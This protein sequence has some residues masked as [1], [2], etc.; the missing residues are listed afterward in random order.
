MANDQF[1]KLLRFARRTGDRLIITDEHGGEPLVILP[2]E[3]YESLVDGFLGPDD[4]EIAE[5]E[6]EHNHTGHDHQQA[7]QPFEPEFE[8]EEEEIGEI[9]IDPAFLAAPAEEPILEVIEPRPIPASIRPPEPPRQPPSQA[10]NQGGEEQ[11]YLEP[12]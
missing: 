4:G 11:F 10:Q 12:L 1:Q 6:A 2:F 7:E 5:L 9:E 8:S 3:Q